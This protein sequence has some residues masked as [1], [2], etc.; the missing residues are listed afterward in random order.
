MKKFLALLLCL[1]TAFSVT[2]C[3]SQDGE[4]NSTTTVIS[5]HNYNGGVG[6]KWLEDAAARF[7]ALKT[8]DSYEEGKTGVKIDIAANQQGELS[9]MATSGY[10]MFFFEQHYDIRNLSQ[11]EKLLDVSDVLTE[12]SN[13]ERDG[14]KVS[15]EDKIPEEYR[16]AL[17]GADGK[18]YGLP[19]YSWYPGLT[20]DRELFDKYNFYFA[21]PDEANKQK[22]ETQFGGEHYF[23][24]DK[25][26][27]KSCGSDGKYG[28]ADDGLPSSVE[29]FLV[30]C[31]YMKTTYG[32]QPVTM[33]GAYKY[34]SNYLVEG[35]WA[36]LSGGEQMK[37]NYTFTGD[38]DVV[39]GYTNENLFEGID[40]VKKPIVETKSV[41]EATGYLAYD[42]VYRYY[43]AS[44][45]KILE[46]EKFFSNDAT[47]G[48]VSHT[49][50]Q[51]DF[52]FSGKAQM[53]KTAMLIEGTYWYNETEEKANNLTDYYSDPRNTE[54]DVRWMNLPT[55]ISGS[56]EPVADDA[57]ARKN[58]A[59]E[60]G[61]SFLVV[62][63]NIEGKT[64]LI[65]A[66]KDFIKFLYTDSELEAFTVSTGIPKAMLDYEVSDAKIADLPEFKK[67]VINFAKTSD[68]VYGAADNETFL[69]N[70]NDV[71]KI[72]VNAPVFVPKYKNV[73]YMSYFQAYE[74]GATAQDVFEAT[75]INAEGWKAYYVGN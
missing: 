8:A 30:L 1:F 25:N 17:K 39:T 38:V 49:T 55:L 51:G 59:V 60:T 54:R 7:T 63:A 26:G 3:G 50:A 66:I 46:K 28:T 58:T 27:K 73:S 10:N 5:V 20:Y 23:I 68:V 75:R 21:A 33:A 69:K 14:V 9:T 36:S 62:N 18:Y 52:I 15:I 43:A 35:L 34:Y 53:P 29:E 2:A 32:V 37:A 19:H 71:F 65:N 67:S 4:D 74:N 24:A 64:G 56:A 16:T 45:V 44:L 47:M 31:A 13:D 42:S 40:Y 22:I 57:P 70:G 11:G 6:N 61:G 12:K 41:T 48:S 72:R